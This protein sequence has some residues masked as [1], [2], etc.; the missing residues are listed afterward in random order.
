MKMDDLTPEEQRVADIVLTSH[1]EM[2][3]RAARFA[4]RQ[5][6][7]VKVI[8]DDRL[9]ELGF[10]GA[11][12]C[13]HRVN[14]SRPVQV[15]PLLLQVLSLLLTPALVLL[16]RQEQMLRETALNSRL[17]N[18]SLSDGDLTSPSSSGAKAG[19]ASSSTREGGAA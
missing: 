17:P 9:S 10:V 12:Q 1:N 14:N 8:V 18:L 7:T 16:G 15:F 3:A 11:C 2:P 4:E 5:K 19:G 13:R 6:A